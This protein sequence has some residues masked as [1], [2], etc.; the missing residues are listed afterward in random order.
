M[1]NLIRFSYLLLII[2]FGA[3][4]SFD[5][6]GL[7]SKAD[8]RLVNSWALQS[9]LLNGTDAT[10]SINI[11][12]LKEIY[13]EDGTYERSYTDKDGAPFTES[14]V[15]ELPD[16]ADVINIS[17][18][19]SLELS[20]QNSTVSS[21]HYNIKRLKKDEYWYSYTNGGATHEFHFILQ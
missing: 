8:N 21:D 9:Y 1:K 12:D 14:G 19:S 3:C 4:Q 10:S 15:Y 20:D 18:V 6:G 11:S 16:K 17:S 7:V 13:H 5:D 2:G